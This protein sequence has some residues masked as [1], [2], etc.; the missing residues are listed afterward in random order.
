[1]LIKWDWIHNVPAV[2][3]SGEGTWAGARELLTL[4]LVDPALPSADV[5]SWLDQR[6]MAVHSRV[7]QARR[8]GTLA[9][10]DPD[11]DPPELN[12]WAFVLR[13]HFDMPALYRAAA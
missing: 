10:F 6:T 12:E 2:A 9:T 4:P 8:D 3:S 5:A 11:L 13:G 1:M 7:M